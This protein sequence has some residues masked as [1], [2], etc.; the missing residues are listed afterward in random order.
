MTT[1]N[2]VEDTRVVVYSEFVGSIV[3]SK[4]LHIKR[5]VYLMANSSVKGSIYGRDIH[6]QNGADVSGPILASRNVSIELDSNVAKE[7]HFGSDVY[8]GDSISV[9]GPG[10]EKKKGNSLNVLGDIYSKKV[11]LKNARVGGSIIGNT[12]VLDNCAIYG[13]VI[14]R[15]GAVT[16]DNSVAFAIHSFGDIRARNSKLFYP[17]LFSKSGKISIEGEVNIV[18]TLDKDFVVRNSDISS[19]PNGTYAENYWRN[20]DMKVYESL[21]TEATTQYFRTVLGE[22]L[23]P[24]DLLP[25]ERPEA[26]YIQ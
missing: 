19:G 3:P 24:R 11:Q 17:F 22:R 4:Q 9:S 16:I 13:F 12:I 5:D 15:N 2:V 26:K 8:S 21:L 6:V 7:V 25:S 20:L 1:D 23:R 18:M 10:Q 14:S